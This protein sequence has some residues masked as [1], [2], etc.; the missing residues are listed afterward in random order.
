MLT[1][2][3]ML[4][5][6]S[7]DESG[8][9]QATFLRRHEDAIHGSEE[10]RIVWRD[11]EY[12]RSNEDRRIEEIAGLVA[13]NKAAEIVAVACTLLAVKSLVGGEQLPWVMISS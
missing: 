7:V 3:G 10:A 13:L 9:C 5:V 6:I 1:V 11:E 4:G 2:F 12:E 8:G